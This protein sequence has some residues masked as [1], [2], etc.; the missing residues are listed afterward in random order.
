M[1]EG[2]I[3]KGVGGNYTIKDNRTKELIVASMRGKFRY[4]EVDKD[5][6]F[7]KQLTHK[8]KLE[9]KTLKISPKVGDFV[10]YSQ[11]DGHATIDEIKPRKNDLMRP[12]IANVD[13]VFIIFACA[14]PAM[15]FNLLDQFLVLM[16]REGVKTTIIMTKIDLLSATMLIDLK[17][18]MKYYEDIG[19]KVYFVNSKTGEGLEDVKPLFTGKISVLSGQTGAGKST[20]INAL[21]PG[22]KLRTQEISKALGRGKH[23][24]TAVELYDYNGGLLADTPGF[25]KLDFSLILDT[26][27][28]NYFI[29]FKDECR[30]R[31]CLHDKEP[32]CMVKKHVA[33][34]TIAKWRYDNYLRFLNELRSINKK[35]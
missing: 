28:K 30:F 32:G 29:E 24:T 13:E 23:T 19:Y 16:A 20:F 4:M 17:T 2:R 21:I 15:Q 27:L 8:R 22:Y 11:A 9:T 25:S 14:N 1:S 6:C 31:G 33:D 35:Y 7:N 34:G 5:S 3:I 10:V 26:E 12:A 18:K